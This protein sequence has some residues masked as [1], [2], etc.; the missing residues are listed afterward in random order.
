MLILYVGVFE[1]GREYFTIITGYL[2]IL[3]S[4]ETLPSTDHE[5]YSCWE[6]VKITQKILTLTFQMNP[7]R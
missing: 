4:R 3:Q 6:K 1:G 5:T 7:Y 2:A